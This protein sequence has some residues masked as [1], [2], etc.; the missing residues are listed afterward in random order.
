ML[1]FR[2]LAIIFVITLA[3]P[4]VTAY[5][6]MILPPEPLVILPEDCQ[7]PVD[8]EIRL[9]L[10][11]HIPSDMIVSWDVDQG[12]ISYVLPGRSAVFVAPSTPAVVTVTASLSPA[13]PGFT[14]SITRQC[15]V[16]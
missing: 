15:T 8:E 13:I 4:I 14:A 7:V 9:E 5:G 3:L 1:M 16:K 10:D 12:G 2:N 11:G 6:A